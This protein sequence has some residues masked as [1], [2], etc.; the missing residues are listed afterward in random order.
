[1][2]YEVITLS[3]DCLMKYIDFNEDITGDMLI[4][5]GTRCS[6]VEM[7]L[8]KKHGMDKKILEFVEN[9]GIVLGICGGYQTLGKMLIDEDFSEGD[10]GTISGLGIFDM[11]TTFGNKK[12]IKNSIGII[13]IQNQNFNAM[14]YE[15]HEGY[16]LSN[17][18]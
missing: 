8:M 9:G 4:L 6:T 12:A 2:L 16:S 15:L 5:P 1:M 14:G 7:D 3:S 11:E 18:V 17:V 10:V 13:S